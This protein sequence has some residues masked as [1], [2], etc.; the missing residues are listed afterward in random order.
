[1]TRNL[2]NIVLETHKTFAQYARSARETNEA[3]MAI[4]R[5]LNEDFRRVGTYFRGADIRSP[6]SKH[7]SGRIPLPPIQAIQVINAL[8]PEGGVLGIRQSVMIAE[9]GDH[10][11]NHEYYLAKSGKT[12][13]FYLFR[14]YDDETRWRK[15]NDTYNTK[16]HQCYSVLSSMGED[17]S[18]IHPLS[19]YSNPHLK[20]VRFDQS[21]L[22]IDIRWR[23]LKV[24]E[25]DYL[26]FNKSGEPVIGAIVTTDGKTTQPYD[27][28]HLLQTI[29]EIGGIK[30][31]DKMQA[32]MK[33]LEQQQTAG[34]I[35][36]ANHTQAPQ[37]HR[38]P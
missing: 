12:D 23:F 13:P 11:H 18:F 38:Q 5:S 32:Y 33:K 21:Q 36:P 29:Y 37:S 3:L 22:V 26:L 19:A 14:L 35:R 31:P 2:A 34:A 16:I 15:R 9:P 20:T 6:T 30:C 7:Y 1:M 8:L 4:K 10:A 17:A 28:L 24:F 27:T 25:N